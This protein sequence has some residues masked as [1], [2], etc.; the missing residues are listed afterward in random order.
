MQPG[1]GGSR[2]YAAARLTDW[3]TISSFGTAGGT[4]ALA[5]ATFSS[6]RSAQRSTRLAE[7]SLLASQRPVLI[8][9]RDDDP[10]ERIRFGDGVFVTV[11]GHEGRAELRDGRV[12][13]ALSLR[14]G[15]AGVAV[16]HGWQVEAGPSSAN[17][18]AP[19][20]SEFHRQQRDLYIPSG[21]TGFW[22]AAIRDAGDP[23]FE[24]LRAAAEAGSRV[25][26]SL[27]YGDHEG[28]QRT[29]VRFGVTAGSAEDVD[30]RS[31][32]LKYWNV[33]TADPR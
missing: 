23:W 13:M 11:D 4:L 21:Q 27:L 8:P 28:G 7:R 31:E 1:R 12:Y 29:I 30:R 10:P 20:L 26:I 14:N 33:D 3:A 5:A 24:P 16:I 6:I 25:M 18:A 22:Q 2:G 19:G 15:G 17:M 9:S 32:L